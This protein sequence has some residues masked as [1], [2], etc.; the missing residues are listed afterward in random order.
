MIPTA[1]KIARAEALREKIVEQHALGL[2][3]CEIRDVL[4]ITRSQ[5]SYHSKVLR[6]AGRITKSHTAKR[7]FDIRLG[8]M[9]SVFANTDDA[10]MEWAHNQTEG[11]ETVAEFLRDLVLDR[12]YDEHE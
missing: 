1:E 7:G 9:S 6:S 12:Y 2:R 4:G 11:Y 8:S 10:L 5:Y 3:P